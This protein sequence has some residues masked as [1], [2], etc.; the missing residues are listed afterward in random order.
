ML[1]RG[2]SEFAGVT[3]TIFSLGGVLDSASEGGWAGHSMAW[4][5]AWVDVLSPARFLGFPAFFSVNSV[6]SDPLSF[7]RWRVSKLQLVG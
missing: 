1:I 3:P 7:S 5:G 2:D 6:F 4:P